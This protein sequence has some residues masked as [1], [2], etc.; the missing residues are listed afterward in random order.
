MLGKFQMYLKCVCFNG[1][2]RKFSGCFI[3]VSSELQRSVK[4]VSWKIECKS[5]VNSI[6][7]CVTT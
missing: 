7:V 5:S 1:V 4:G 6:L 3:E 2:S